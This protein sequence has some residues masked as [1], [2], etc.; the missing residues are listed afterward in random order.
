MVGRDGQHT[1][2]SFVGRS[3]ELPWLP[4]LTLVHG[5][6]TI[7]RMH[8]AV[9]DTRTEGPLGREFDWVIHLEL[10]VELVLRSCDRGCEQRDGEGDDKGGPE[11]HAVPL[12]RGRPTE[13]SRR[14]SGM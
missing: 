2:K 6:I 8:S 9:L 11:L 3:Y 4:D 7:L 10:V 1:A 12:M 14:R 5:G 13:R